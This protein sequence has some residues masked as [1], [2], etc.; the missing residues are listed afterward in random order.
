[1]GVTYRTVGPPT[2]KLVDIAPDAQGFALVY[3]NEATGE[4]VLGLCNLDGSNYRVIYTEDMGGPNGFPVVAS[5][6][7]AT[8]VA[9]R[10]S[11]S[12]LGTVWNVTTGKRW[13]IGIVH[14]NYP[15]AITNGYL[16]YLADAQFTVRR[17][18]LDQLDA[19]QY[20]AIPNVVH[21]TG[22]AYAMPLASVDA[23]RSSVPG[24]VNPRQL[25]PTHRFVGENAS[26]TDRNIV[27]DLDTHDVLDL[28]S[29]AYSPLPR[30][31]YVDETHLAVVTSGGS[32]VRLATFAVSDL[33]PPATV[34]APLPDV[35]W[36]TDPHGVAEDVWPWIANNATAL[37]PDGR[38]AWI[39]K[40]DEANVEGQ[41]HGEHWD[42]DATYVGHL[43]DSSS[44]YRWY[45]AQHKRVNAIDWVN[46]GEP[47]PWASLPLERNCFD[48]GARLWLPR[49]CV[50][51][52]RQKF[53]TNIRW[54]PSGY[55]QPNIPM[56]TIVD[57][58]YARF[59]G[60]EAFVRGV[61]RSS[62][63][64]GRTWNDEV[65]LYGPTGWVTHTPAG[66]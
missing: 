58:G 42:S 7:G 4:L 32:G 41:T 21:G 60:R 1:M 40:S 52:Y 63:D 23:V 51:G 59:G 8:W 54:A 35:P 2:G 53:T 10:H 24:L 26:G 19:P 48:A 22:I 30:G 11:P 18:R 27:T 62:G 15:I 44:G 65:N 64:G 29:G 3:Q 5:W 14:G 55:V 36:T 16:A 46:M 33:R 31:A 45:A 56:E 39:L 12:N 43:E 13:T 49:R 47:E 61:Y 6:A 17:K 38:V 20:E 50:T 66:V 25:G 57:V 9:W 34:P 28:W 37:S